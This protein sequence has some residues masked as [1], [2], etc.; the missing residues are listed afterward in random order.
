MSGCGG[1][2]TRAGDQAGAHD[3]ARAAQTP[4]LPAPD[5]ALP[6]SPSTFA[7]DLAS[8]TLRLRAAVSRWTSAGEP[9][10]ADPP[11]DVTLL[12]LRHQRLHRRLVAD[13]RM[14]RQVFALLSRTVLGEVRDTVAARRSL[15]AIPASGGSTPPVRTAQAQPPAVLLR[16]YRRAERR[17]GVSRH[18]LAAVNFIESA[19]GKVRSASS[20]GARGPMQFLPA[21]WRHYGLGGDIDDAGDAILG[22]ANY[23]RAAGAPRSYRRA[24]F[25]YNHSTAYV[26]AVLRYASR[27]RADPRVFYTYY[28]WQVYARTPAGVRRLTGPR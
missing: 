21:T 24:L 22:A 26:D 15:A 11:S 12:A 1:G 8:T 23:L 9:T 20:A 28:A 16:S 25:A 19:F 3:P 4:A 7:R 10:S 5:G 6:R 18:V 13:A 17:F 14:S 27:V 2:G